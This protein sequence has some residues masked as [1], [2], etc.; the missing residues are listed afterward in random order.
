MKR[1]AYF[2]LCA[3]L[4]AACSNEIPEKRII[5]R[6]GRTVLAYLVANNNLDDELKANVTWMYEALA[7]MKDSCTLLVYYR[8]PVS[9]KVIEK[10]VLME[11][12]CNGEGSINGR[13]A[14]LGK[15]L[16][17]E[18]V[19]Q[20]SHIVR[21]YDEKDYRS[22]D[23][24]V[25]RQVFRD[26]QDVAP[27]DSYGLIFG[28]HASG[29]LPAN[30]TI[31]SKAFGDDGGYNINIPELSE[32][33][34]SGF[35]KSLDFILFDACMMGTAEVC[36]E[37]K[38]VTHYCIASVME[39]PADGFPYDMLLGDL[40]ASRI[41]FNAVCNK[42]I[43][44]N[45]TEGT[46]GTCASIDCSMMEEL[47]AV[48]KAELVKNSD[49]FNGFDYTEVKQYG[50]RGEIDYTY[51]SF[52]LADFFRQFN[53]GQ[54]P[55]AIQSALNKVVVAK[56][57]LSDSKY[58]PVDETRFCGIGMYY[59]KLEKSWNPYYKA[60]ISWYQAVGWEQVIN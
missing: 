55:S 52:D 20:Q 47:A 42:F 56:D 26:M 18:Y 28:S 38:D 53:G 57:C 27:S 34:R 13:K 24:L 49:L 45:K 51:F 2:L 22:V 37:L 39:T 17:F 36:Y 33:I 30:T 4:L 7:S 48:V 31:N 5:E 35:S 6:S 32:A 16:T 9:D 11:F 41:D 54:I 60:S 21:E 3:F 29:W 15:E 10:P 8:P 50:L 43:A 40:Y 19:Y 58:Y 44:F 25:M 12:L 14:L 1:A 46:W 23:P 59:P